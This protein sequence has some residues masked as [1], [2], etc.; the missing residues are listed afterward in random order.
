MDNIYLWNTLIIIRIHIILVWIC[1]RKHHNRILS[2]QPNVWYVSVI[3]YT[4]INTIFTPTWYS[5]SKQEKWMVHRIFAERRFCHRIEP[6]GAPLQHC[7][8]FIFTGQV[9]NAQHMLIESKHV[10]YIL[11]ISITHLHDI[12]E[13]A[14]SKH[15]QVIVIVTINWTTYCVCV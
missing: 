1:T 2:I 3:P 6:F 8:Q 13:N 4:V 9:M 14:Y 15:H 12:M 10:E 11:G 5:R 7:C